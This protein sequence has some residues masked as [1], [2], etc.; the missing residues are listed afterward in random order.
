M[1]KPGAK[2]FVVYNKKLLLILRDNN[3]GISFPNTWNLPGGGIEEGES[4]LETIRRELQ[5]EI[6]VVPENILELGQQT[7]ED[8]S[9]LFRYLAKLT[10][11]EYQNLKLGNE[12]QKMDFFSVDEA[13][14]LDLAGYS[15]EYFIKYKNQIKELIE[16]NKIPKLELLDLV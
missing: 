2:A 13:F 7:F 10:M 12:G 6:G 3:P 4:G 15:K 8:G 11:D 9:I 5:E 16:E 1:K 14:K